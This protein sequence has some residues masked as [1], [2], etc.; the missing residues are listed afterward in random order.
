LV[1]L[2]I[3]LDV[4]ICDMDESG[5][6]AAINHVSDVSKQVNATWNEIDG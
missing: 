3:P 2:G 5:N 6:I 4:H 1:F